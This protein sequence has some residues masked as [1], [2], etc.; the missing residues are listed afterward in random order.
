MNYPK[1]LENLWRCVSDTPQFRNFLD[2]LRKAQDQHWH[3]VSAATEL[4]EDDVR[5]LHFFH[6]R[7]I[8]PFSVARQHW[9]QLDFQHRSIL[10]DGSMQD[11]PGTPAG[12]REAIRWAYDRFRQAA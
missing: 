11:F 8:Q 7:G 4:D 12:Y 1:D 10:P 9:M 5:M 6:D 2:A 3:D